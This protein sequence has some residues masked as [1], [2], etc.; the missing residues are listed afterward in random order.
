MTRYRCRCHGSTYNILGEK[1]KQGPA[2]R[3]MD[4]FPVS[5]EEGVVVVDTSQRVSGP[6]NLG[7]ERLAFRDAHPWE[8]TCAEL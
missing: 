8:A 2:E 6:P 4:R 3:G 7:P 5:I 1:L